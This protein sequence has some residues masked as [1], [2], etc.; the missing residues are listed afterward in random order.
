MTMRR[1]VLPFVISFCS[2]PAV[3][4]A[5]A[6]GLSGGVLSNSDLSGSLQWFA[7]LAGLALVPVLLVMVTAFVKVVVVL[8]ILR[9]ALGIQGVP[10]MQIIIGLALILTL[11]IMAPRPR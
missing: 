5:H 6:D 2:L 1:V 11:F 8:G 4:W 7:I 3:A 9:S 10:P